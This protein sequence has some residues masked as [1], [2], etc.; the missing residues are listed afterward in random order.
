MTA[1]PRVGALLLLLGLAACG[2]KQSSPFDGPGP[3][4]GIV[5]LAVENTDF[6]DATIY[7][8]AEGR[9]TRLGTVSGKGTAQFRIGWVTLRDLAVE[10][11]LFAGQSFTTPR[12]T[13]APGDRLR[14]RIERPLNNSFV[15]R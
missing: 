10:I 2:S 12:V 8:V 11:N 1:L 7:T 3:G 4:E 5:T 6:S 14:L 15:R 9:R 13:V